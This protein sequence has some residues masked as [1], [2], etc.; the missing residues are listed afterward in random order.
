MHRTTELR[1]RPSKF[2]R[3]RC[4]DALPIPRPAAPDQVGRRGGA[5]ERQLLPS[6]P[7]GNPRSAAPRRVFASE[8]GSAVQPK[9]VCYGRPLRGWTARFGRPTEV[10]SFPDETILELGS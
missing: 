10:R 5:I 3:T 6:G 8:S 2:S 4:S 1:S 7:P 9:R